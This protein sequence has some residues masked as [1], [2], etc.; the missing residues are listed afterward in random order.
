MMLRSGL[1]AYPT[2]SYYD[3]NRPS[4]MPYWLD[5]A[6]EEALK[7]GLYPGVNSLKPLPTPVA[8][9]PQPPAGA[10]DY[11]PGGSSTSIDLDPATT[12][13][14]WFGAAA[15]TMDTAAKQIAE[16]KKAAGASLGMLPW[17]AAGVV[18]VLILAK[19]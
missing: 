1:G 13:P 9:V 2:D 17:I 3:P 11:T 16:E 12:T 4:W 18:V 7:F 10:L 15:Q 8:P 6:S 14:N 19:R 5:T